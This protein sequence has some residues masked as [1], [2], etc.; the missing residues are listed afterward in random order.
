MNKMMFH[1]HLTEYIKNYCKDEGIE[2][3]A[4]FNASVNI[5]KEGLNILK[6][7]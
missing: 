7:K 6:N 5:A 1:S 3:N 4:D 2:I